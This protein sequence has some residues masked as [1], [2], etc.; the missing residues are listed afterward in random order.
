MVS[1]LRPTE[2][3]IASQLITKVANQMW[4]AIPGPT[5]PAYIIM[6]VTRVQYKN[7][8]PSSAEFMGM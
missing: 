1:L 2:F 3:V 5:Q 4:Y 6:H 7:D 8:P